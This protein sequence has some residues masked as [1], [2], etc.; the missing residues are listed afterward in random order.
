MLQTTAWPLCLSKCHSCRKGLADPLVLFSCELATSYVQLGED[1][2]E[3]QGEEGEVA[4]NE[5]DV[6]SSTEGVSPFG[7]HCWGIMRC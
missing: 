6:G 1:D 7:L 2:K 4:G 3:Q 5:D